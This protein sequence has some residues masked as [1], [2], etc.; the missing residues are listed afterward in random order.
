[1]LCVHGAQLPWGELMVE[2]ILVLAAGQ[3]TTTLRALP[4]MLEM[5]ITLVAEQTRRVLH[6]AA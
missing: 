2:G 1:M 6:A 3:V 5:Q 4:P